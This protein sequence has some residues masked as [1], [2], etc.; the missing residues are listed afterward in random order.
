MLFDIEY[1]RNNTRWSHSSTE[2]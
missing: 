1:R 2:R